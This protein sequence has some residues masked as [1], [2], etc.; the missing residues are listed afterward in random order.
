M[1]GDLKNSSVLVTGATGLIGQALV[2]KLLSV[3]A[4]VVVVA[5]NKEKANRL[6]GKNDEIS[7]VFSDVT[8]LE[9]CKF[10]VDYIIHAASNTSSKA[11]VTDP[12]GVIDI[13]LEGTKRTLEIARLSAVKSYV[14]LSSMEVYGVPTTDEKID[15]LHACNL[16]TMVARSAYPESK[17]MSENL[18]ASY[19]SQFGVPVKV[20][21]LTQ[22]FGPGVQYN[23]GRV[24]AEFARC[25]IERK[26]I[27]LHTKGETRRNYLY[28]D[29]A[30]E[31]IL[32]VLLKGEAGEAYNAAN[33]ETYCSIYEM[34][35]LVAKEFGEGRIRVIIDEKDE[36]SYGYAP[37]LHM[38]LNTEKLRELGWFPKVNLKEMFCYLIRSMSVC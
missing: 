10:D 36:T 31:A 24:F 20:V 26:D 23:D 29:D 28:I 32:T 11:F 6:F 22:S 30:V 4:K 38:N 14:Y 21:R 35:Q 16:N 25:V 3:G 19:M 7:Y 13:A 12:V 37:T 8:E 5:R 27:V 18:C 9:I 34:A 1:F 2:K 17:R 33:E 15:E